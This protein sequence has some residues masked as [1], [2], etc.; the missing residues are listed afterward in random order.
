[1]AVFSDQNYIS[2][3]SYAEGFFLRVRIVAERVFVSFVM[4][5]SPSVCF[6]CISASPA[7]RIS[8]EFDIDFCENM[9]R[10]LKLGYV[11]ALTSLS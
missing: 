9:S 6:T 10:N 1:M 2:D 3:C 4:S 11:R 5:I 8:I 7:G